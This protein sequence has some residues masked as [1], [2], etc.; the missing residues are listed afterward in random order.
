MPTVLLMP[1]QGTEGSQKLSALL[2][3][4]ALWGSR[5][6]LQ[7]N[8]PKENKRGEIKNKVSGLPANPSSS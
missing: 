7:K 3:W 6:W 8:S 1:Q 2:P 5:I 4:A